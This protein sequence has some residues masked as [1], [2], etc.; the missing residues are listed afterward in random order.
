MSK[1]ERD[2]IKNYVEQTN[3]G[4]I[5]RLPKNRIGYTIMVFHPGVHP[6]KLR[7]EEGVRE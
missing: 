5:I 3:M 6:G 2:F 7:I 4:C 1:K